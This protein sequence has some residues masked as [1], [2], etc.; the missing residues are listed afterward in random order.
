[1]AVW[2]A[3]AQTAQVSGVIRDEFN[4]PV[5]GANIIIKGTYNGTTTDLDGG[6]T[7][8]MNKPGK[9]TLLISY[10][11]YKPTD[12]EVDT[13][14]G[15][16]KDLG[17]IKLKPGAEQLAMATPSGPIFSFSPKGRRSSPS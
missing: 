2:T 16:N 1:M 8:E 6:F 7:L 3:A 13:G 9:V 10:L 14:P 11:G 17:T 15:E 12:L 4:E 5:T